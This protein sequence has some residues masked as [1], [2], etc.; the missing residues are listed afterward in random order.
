MARQYGKNI[1][2]FKKENTRPS[3]QLSGMNLVALKNIAKFSKKHK[4]KRYADKNDFPFAPIGTTS[5]DTSI[6]Q[7]AGPSLFDLASYKNPFYNYLQTASITRL[8]LGQTIKTTGTT[9]LSIQRPKLDN[10]L[11]KGDDFYLFNAKTFNSKE[12]TC[13]ADLSSSDDTITI[14]STNFNMSDWFPTGSFVVADNQ[15]AMQRN[16]SAIDYRKIIVDNSAY[17]ALNT[18]PITL[19]AAETDKTHLP[20]SCYIQYLHLTDELSNY[21]LYIGHDSGS[22]TI[23]DY[24]GSIDSFAYRERNNVLYQI[25]ASTFAAGSPTDFSSTPM[26]I[27]SSAGSGL[28]LYLYTTGNYTSS[29]SCVLHLHYT[30]LYG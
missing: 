28:G 3:S 16:A 19:L 30:T 29:S 12:L 23:G 26:K 15:R 4:N 2:L 10:L 13:D 7:D 27:D 17:T 21:D 18:N 9:S 11:K 14:T 25:G 8:K 1:D 20:I 22:T 5:T 24:W 6:Y